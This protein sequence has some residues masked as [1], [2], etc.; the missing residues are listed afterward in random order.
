VGLLNRSHSRKNP[1]HLA[2]LPVIGERFETLT[3]EMERAGEQAAQPFHI[4]HSGSWCTASRF[5]ISRFNCRAI[6]S[7]TLAMLL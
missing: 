1:A 7:V 3:E 6:M 2:G 4:H 5:V